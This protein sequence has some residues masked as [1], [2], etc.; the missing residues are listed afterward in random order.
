MDVRFADNSLKKE[1][2]HTGL[3]LNCSDSPA[4]SKTNGTASCNCHDH[5][6]PDC[7]IT[8]PQLINT[9]AYDPR[10]FKPRD[11]K[12][13]LFWKLVARDAEPAR[14][15]LIFNRKGVRFSSLD[16][17][18]GWYFAFSSPPDPMHAVVLGK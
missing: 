7:K 14:K 4:R 11:P 6:C 17:I 5:M 15:E 2:V 16:E 18:A 9:A 1:L 12:T 8:F 13:Q 3:F 10:K